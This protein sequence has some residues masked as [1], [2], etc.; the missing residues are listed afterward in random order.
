[1]L[2]RGACST[3]NVA[4]QPGSSRLPRPPRLDATAPPLSFARRAARID[5]PAP[6][7]PRLGGRRHSAPPCVG[8]RTA[9]AGRI[10]AALLSA[11][12]VKRNANPR[13]LSAQRPR[14][15]PGQGTGWLAQMAVQLTRASRAVS[16]GAAPAL[17]AS[18]CG[19]PRSPPAVRCRA[20][21]TRFAFS[22]SSGWS[23]RVRLPK[24]Y[25]VPRGTFGRRQTRTGPGPK[26][27][28]R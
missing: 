25:L 4:G 13:S 16:Q 28:F 14:G 20:S 10:A 19:H 2:K 21:L 12:A 22:Q 1:M 15:V 26:Q 23:M 7:W 27:P 3:W 18:A 9:A 5:D 17:T 8:T 11:R 24:A 6:T